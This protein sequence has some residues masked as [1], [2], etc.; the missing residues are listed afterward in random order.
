MRLVF[1]NTKAQIILL[2]KSMMKDIMLFWQ[3][4]SHA[5]LE[6]LKTFFKLLSSNLSGWATTPMTT[7][8]VKKKQSSFLCVYGAPQQNFT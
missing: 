8:A 3:L 4:W 2:N 6:V 1:N 7:P 5:T